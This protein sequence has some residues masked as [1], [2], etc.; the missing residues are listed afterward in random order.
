[1][2][3]AVPGK[4]IAIKGDLATVDY[5]GEKREGKIVEGTYKVGDFVIIQGKIVLEKIP[6]EEVKEWH[7]FFNPAA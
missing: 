5:G 2:C 3:L 7:K 6:P 1:M 4:I